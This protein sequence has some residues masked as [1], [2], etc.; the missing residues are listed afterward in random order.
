MKRRVVSALIVSA[1]LFSLVMT[2]LAANSRATVCTPE[3]TFNG[4]TA[5]CYV[6]ITDFGKSITAT[7]ELWQGSTRVA[8]W[9]GSGTSRLII[10]E[11]KAVTK[12]KTYT[13][14]VSGTINGEAFTGASISA[15][16]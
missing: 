5:S 2:V 4:T 3:L 13:L 16:C 15:T 9:S 6:S 10:S 8:Q 7:L 14:K 11:T 1:V 12:G